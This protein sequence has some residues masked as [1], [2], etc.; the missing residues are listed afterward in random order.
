MKAIHP[1]TIT[2]TVLTACLTAAAV[3]STRAA[4]Q[5]QKEAQ[6]ALHNFVQKDPGIEK[7]VET[8]AGY[9]IFPGVGEGGF[10]VGGAHGKGVVYQKGKAIGTATVT[11]ATIGAQVGGQSFAE[12]IFFQNPD[13]LKQFKS[14]NLELSAGVGAVVA[15]E[16][17]AETAAYQQGIAVFTMPKSGVMA[18]AAIGGQKFKYQPYD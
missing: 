2:V 7:F 4:D 17:A 1:R 16:G 9:V 8:S 12:I 5:L 18:K 13:T 10:I 3:N 15:A 11:K 14:S 6:D